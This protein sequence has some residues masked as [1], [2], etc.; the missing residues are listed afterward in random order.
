MAPIGLIWEHVPKLDQQIFHDLRNGDHSGH[1]V[2]PSRR[3]IVSDGGDH[4]LAEPSAQICKTSVQTN[5][6]ACVAPSCQRML[7]V[8]LSCA[9][10]AIGL[11]GQSIATS[12]DWHSHSG[13]ERIARIVHW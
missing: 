10:V 1:S 12:L 13:V 4:T 3:R 8:A 9:S 11:P 6:R 7:F 5:L 2:L